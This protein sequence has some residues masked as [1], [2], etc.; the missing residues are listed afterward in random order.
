MKK[1][2]QIGGAATKIHSTRRS[3]RKWNSYDKRIGISLKLSDKKNNNAYRREVP[4]RSKPTFI[5]KIK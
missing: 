3:R 2:M 4:N 1:Q 5:C